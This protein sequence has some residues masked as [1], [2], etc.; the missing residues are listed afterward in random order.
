V[1]RRDGGVSTLEVA[2]SSAECFHE[3]VELLFPRGVSG[4]GVRMV[5]EEEADRMWIRGG[6]GR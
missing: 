3:G 6:E 2:T 5:L 4:D 1:V